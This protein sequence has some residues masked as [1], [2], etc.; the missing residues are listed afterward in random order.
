MTDNNNNQSVWFLTHSSI[1]TTN[2]LSSSYLATGTLYNCFLGFW[3]RHKWK[4]TFVFLLLWYNTVLDVLDRKGAPL[5]WPLL[6]SHRIHFIA[7]FIVH[8]LAQRR[9]WIIC[10][11]NEWMIIPLLITIMI[12]FILSIWSHICFREYWGILFFK[13]LGND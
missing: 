1:I 8:H 3:K 9:C 2:S 6:L 7:H 12:H 5:L 13:C 4:E 11:K 10:S